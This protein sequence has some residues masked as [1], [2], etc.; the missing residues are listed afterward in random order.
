MYNRYLSSDDAPYVHANTAATPH[1]TTGTDHG[2]PS[3]PQGVSSGNNNPFAGG[4]P[5]DRIQNLLGL[6]VSGEGRHKDESMLRRLLV[7]F[8]LEDV[9]TGDLML[10]ILLFFLLEEKA[11]D[12]LLIAL[13]LLLIL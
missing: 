7:R 8:H 6:G 4:S 3:P 1:H 13:G 2:R 10:L 5:V 12:E 11:D 9:D